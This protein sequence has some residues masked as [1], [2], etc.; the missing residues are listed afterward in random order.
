MSRWLN[1][2][3]GKARNFAK[4]ARKKRMTDIFQWGQEWWLIYWVH[5][6]IYDEKNVAGA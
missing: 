1:D 3:V 5:W 6:L 4:Q 2:P